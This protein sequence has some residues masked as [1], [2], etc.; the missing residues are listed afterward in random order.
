MSSK[1]KKVV[2]CDDDMQFVPLTLHSPFSANDSQWVPLVNIDANS[3]NE[4]TNNFFV[5][6]T[7]PCTGNILDSGVVSMPALPIL[8]F[9]EVNNP[10][11]IS[12]ENKSPST[13]DKET[14]GSKKAPKNTYDK[15]NPSTNDTN[16]NI[17]DIDLLY[18]SENPSDELYSYNESN[19]SPSKCIPRTD[20]DDS[21][22]IIIDDPILT[23]MQ[24]L[25]DYDFSY[26]E[27][28]VFTDRS[29][30]C[31]NEVDD[32]FNKLVTESPGILAALKA[33]KVPYPI[34]ML[35]IKKIIKLTLKICK[36]E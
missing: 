26:E 7:P 17:G 6:F 31:K 24:L 16:A 8:P 25:R 32:V 15:N 35:I 33:Y 4:M 2:N 11:N 19:G 22:D 34:S 13:S 36:E 23:H 3:V 1:N 10:I 9:E 20:L 5:G 21:K 28:D 14:S 18:P 27:L 12:N 30:K 29:D